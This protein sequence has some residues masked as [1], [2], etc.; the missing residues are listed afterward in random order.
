MR[1][2]RIILVVAA[3]LMIFSQPV[4]AVDEP[5]FVCFPFICPD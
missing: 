1:L 5:D 4:V 3:A 2:F